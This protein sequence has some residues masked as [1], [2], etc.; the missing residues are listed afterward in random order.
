MSD[1]AR[2]LKIEHRRNGADR[3]ARDLLNHL[4]QLRDYEQLSL[5]DEALVVA[6]PER[7]RNSDAPI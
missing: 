4:L 3:A 1:N 6:L 7:V 2:R 5:L